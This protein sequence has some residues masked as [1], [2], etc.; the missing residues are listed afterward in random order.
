MKH[1]LQNDRIWELDAFR[2]LCILVMVLLHV[3]YDLQ[4]AALDT[5]FISGLMQYGGAAFV[6]LSGLCATLGRHSFRRGLI[7]LGCGLLIT[8]VTWAMAEFGFLPPDV[9]IR[10]GVLH[11]LG[12][13]MIL[14]PLFRKLP[15]WALA[16]LGLGMVVLGFWFQS[17]HVEPPFLFPLG[18]RVSTFSSGDY[19]PLF[20]HLG[21]FFLG[22]VLGKT[23]Y[24]EKKTRFPGVD[25]DHPVVSFLCLCGRQS[26]WIY[27]LH[28]PI[29][30]GV[31]AVL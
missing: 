2:G 22:A 18:L 14:W 17:F 20:P 30:Y 10:F 5:P 7:V 11:M 23:A 6:L 21:W 25:A 19:F 28:Q 4:V 29:V 16:V 3:L 8:G 1:E 26:L 12:A 24:K 15:R 9:V 27:L 13:A 31:L